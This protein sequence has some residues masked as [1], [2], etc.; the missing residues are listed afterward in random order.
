MVPW[1][2]FLPSAGSSKVRGNLAIEHQPAESLKGRRISAER[3]RVD[4]VPLFLG[5]FVICNRLAGRIEEVFS[6]Q[7]V[8]PKD[9]WKMGEV[10]NHGS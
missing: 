2:E 1:L 5:H 7:H 8:S 4:H 10:G 9:F 3:R 6:S